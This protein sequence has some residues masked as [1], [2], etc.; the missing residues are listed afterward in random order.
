MATR[1]KESLVRWQSEAEPY[2]PELDEVREGP[3]TR[4]SRILRRAPKGMAAAA[5][6]LD[7]EP[8]SLPFSRPLFSTIFGVGKLMTRVRR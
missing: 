8:E 2:V 3:D 4:T 7:V 6:K 1:P 5:R